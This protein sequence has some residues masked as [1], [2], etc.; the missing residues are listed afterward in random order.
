MHDFAHQVLTLFEI[1]HP[2]DRIARAGFVLRGVTEPESVSAH[3]H[4]V[5]LLALLFVERY[6]GRYDKGDI[7]AMALIHDLPE[8]RLMDIPMPYADAYLSDAK[9]HAEDAIAHD[10]LDGFPGNLAGLHAAFE[11]AATPEAQL[12]R[13][14]DKVQMMI[15]VLCYERERRGFLEEFW[16][17]PKNFNDYGIAEVSAIFDLICARAGR[18]RPRL[19]PATTP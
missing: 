1:I 9:R 7:L 3:S 5:A 2:L 12:L 6:P 14:L 17:N 4:F 8:A 15:K 10:I 19:N 16:Q 11:A 18:E 13:G